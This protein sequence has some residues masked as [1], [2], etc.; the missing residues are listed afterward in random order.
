[1]R[2]C[3]AVA[4]NDMELGVGHRPAFGGTKNIPL[5]TVMASPIFHRTKPS[6]DYYLN[7]ILATKVRS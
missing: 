1:M 5:I 3:F 7:L 6:Y 4:R 2:D